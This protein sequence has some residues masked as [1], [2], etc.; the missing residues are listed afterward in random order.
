MV[1]AFLRCESH[2]GR[3]LVEHLL[4]VRGRLGGPLLQLAALCHDLGKA[5]EYFQGYL[6]NR[7]PADLRLKQHAR[8]GAE[9]LLELL[10]ER[11]ET[12]Q[13]MAPEQVLLLYLFVRRHHGALDDLLDAIPAR[14]ELLTKQF[15]ALDRSGLTDWLAKQGHRPRDCSDRD[16]T[17]L[18]VRALRSLKAERN[19]GTDM[20]RFQQALG[21]F[22]QL[23][24][25][26]RDSAG[27]YSEGFFDFEPR[28]SSNKVDAYKMQI[29]AQQ[30]QAI[31]LMRSQLYANAK[32]AARGRPARQ[33]SI[34]TL[35][36]P[37]GSGKT[38][39]A[40]QWSLQ[41]R[42]AR[43]ASGLP[44]CPVIY[45]LPF[46]SIIDQNVAILRE[47]LGTGPVDESSLSIHHHLAEPGFWAKKGEESLAQSWTEGW[48]ADFVCTT[49]VQVVNALFHATCWDA[50][51]MAHLTGGILILDEV[52]A[53]PAHLWPVIRESLLSLSTNFGTDV[54]LMT[55]TQPA[56]FDPKEAIEVAPE[57]SA[58]S[59]VFDRYDLFA[60]VK[61]EIELADIAEKVRTCV[62]E[63]GARNCLII[64]NTI[65][66]AF[67]LFILIE[68]SG[69]AQ[70]CR[71]FHLSTNLRPKDR[72]KI[73]GEI[74]SR[75]EGII[76]VSTQVVEAGLDL[77]F[78]VV[79][80]AVAP[81][82]C[83][84]Q[85]AGRSN[86]HGSDHRGR[87]HVVRLKGNSGARIYGNTHMDVAMST[88]QKIGS[89]A[90]PE[91]ELRSQVS[92]YFL[93]LK[94][95]IS[96]GRAR[97]ILDAVQMM[98]FASLRGEG[99]GKDA[100]KKRVTLIEDQY[101]RIP[102]F[103]ETDVEDRMVWQRF[104]AALGDERS[105]RRRA[106]RMLRNELG[107]RIVEVPSKFAAR[108]EPDPKTG[109]VYVDAATS[110]QFYSSVTGWRRC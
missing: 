26:D 44:N 63:Q 82:D 84:V 28:Y 75:S 87:V 106:I 3:L 34:W 29:E 38:L 11:S 42:E 49:F 104:Q 37:T 79:V 110:G 30:G 27:A 21:E 71:C 47:V 41:R 96:H 20:A 6:N 39:A 70:P 12:S 94:Q 31:G 65:R 7:P 78:D 86:R 66:E 92:Q 52:Q 32:R 58:E 57:Q 9:V 23:I 8:A 45:A 56:I 2:P 85:A 76:V 97:A 89:D 16:R 19:S 22:G 46:T 74:A 103:V 48:R 5:T 10:W 18:R 67:D 43:I 102:H 105:K 64:L 33:A 99:P 73:L 69:W 15:G 68:T 72:K 98:E 35:T 100:D 62:V 54:L 77:S 90:V 14:D 81:L 109:L 24:E 101:D 51:R 59:S 1:P 53:V 13:A 107:Q 36:S 60:D 4:D 108:T 91:P 93:E 40:L 61:A 25:A 80:R 50:R 95:R 83:I 55:A 17:G 88:Y